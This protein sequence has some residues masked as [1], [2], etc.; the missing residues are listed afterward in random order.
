M[1]PAVLQDSTTTLRAAAA[2]TAKQPIV[3][4]V[5]RTERLV[6]I[7]RTAT[8]STRQ[9]RRAKNV[10]PVALYA[11]TRSIVLNAIS[12]TI[13][14][15]PIYPAAVA[16]PL[17][18]TVMSKIQQVAYPASLDIT[19]TTVPRPV[20]N[21]PIIVLGVMENGVNSAARTTSTST[22]RACC[23]KK[24]C[25]LTAQPTTAAAVCRSA[26]YVRTGLAAI[27]AKTLTTIKVPL[28]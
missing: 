21:V 16:S 11:P 14:G 2:L 23:V 20:K 10:G 28:V 15:I 18:T 6:G 17:V 25:I 7:A 27:S 3:L 1:E 13:S 5:R 22:G 8:T 9:P 24:A 12:P 4:P 19:L 26:S